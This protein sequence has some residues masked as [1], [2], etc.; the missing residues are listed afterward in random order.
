MNDS[1]SRFNGYL[2]HTQNNNGWYK[3]TMP[4]GTIFA[5]G[6]YDVYISECKVEGNIF[7]FNY[8]FNIP[9]NI[10]TSSGIYFLTQVEMPGGYGCHYVIGYH[11][12]TAVTGQ[13][14]T[15]LKNLNTTAKLYVFGFE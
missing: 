5:M 14:Y 12:S 4:D 11:N 1:L 9:N 2:T 15:N 8:N 13:F 3:W 7:Y 6:K 10:F